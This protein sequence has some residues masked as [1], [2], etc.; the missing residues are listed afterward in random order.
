MPGAQDNYELVEDRSMK[1]KSCNIVYY[2]QYKNL[3]KDHHKPGKKGR[4]INCTNNISKG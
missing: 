1:I 2:V 3:Y 4:V